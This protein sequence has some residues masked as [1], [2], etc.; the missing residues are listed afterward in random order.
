MAMR[1]WTY[2]FWRPMTTF[3][4]NQQWNSFKSSRVETK[5][6]GDVPTSTFMSCLWVQG[7]WGTTVG[8]TTPRS[9]R[10]P[11]RAVS[12]HCASALLS[13]LRSQSQ[14]TGKLFPTFSH[15]HKRTWNAVA[16]CSVMGLKRGQERRGMEIGL[17]K[18][19]CLPL[20]ASPLVF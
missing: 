20:K 6:T 5:T 12:R 2:V 19:F 16:Q 14:A 18:I 3:H 7:Y 1:L 13:P 8:P 11:C 15:R 17:G 9:S 4:K 10:A